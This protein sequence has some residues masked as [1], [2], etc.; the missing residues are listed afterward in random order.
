MP[1]KKQDSIDLFIAYAHQD[2]E[3][4]SRLHTHLVSLQRTNLIQEIWYDK[5]IQAGDEWEKT[6][7]K[8]LHAADI[9]LLLISV[10]FLASDY[11]FGKEMQDALRLHA[12]GKTKVLPIIL[13]ACTWKL[14]PIAHIEVLPHKGKHVKS[15]A[16]IDEALHEV[17]EKIAEVAQEIKEKRLREERERQAELE[18]QRLAEEKRKQ[19]EAERKEQERL[20]ALARQRAAEEKRKRELADSI[21]SLM[22]KIPAGTFMM[23]DKEW[24]DSQPIHQVHIKAFEMC[25]YPVTQKLWQQ[26]MGTNPSYFKGED[27]PVENVSWEDTQLFLEK[28]KAQTGK[29]YRL[30]SEAE[31]EYAARGGQNF[32]YAGSNNIEEVAWYEENSGNTT[33]PVG[34]KK[35]NGY[36]LYDMSGNVWE[37]CED[38]WHDSYNDAPTDSSAWTNIKN[39]YR[40]LRGGSWYTYTRSCRVSIRFYDRLGNRDYK[41]GF[42]LVCLP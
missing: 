4:Q 1:E 37:W 39:S 3:L 34:N 42:R 11:C 32:L 19:E 16:D 23:G 2:A 29:V 9:I 26:V 30:S 6:I 5:L 36:G 10:D 20:A 8:K 38:T 41:F 27:L 24:I 15:Y 17:I 35:P 7:D 25:K 18:R 14:S 31:W 40:V 22:V 13:G 33:H 21:A 28:L 12:Q